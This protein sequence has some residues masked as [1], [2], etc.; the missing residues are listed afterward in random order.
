MPGWIWF[1]LIGVVAVTILPFGAMVVYKLVFAAK[2]RA[3][4]R[5][6]WRKKRG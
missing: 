1:I 2:Y 3:R 5:R 4:I 6:E